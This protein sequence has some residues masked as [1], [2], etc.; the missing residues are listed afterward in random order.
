[1]KLASTLAALLL[2]A[3]LAPLSPVRAASGFI[4]IDDKQYAWALDSINFMKDRNVINGYPPD[5][6]FNPARGVSRAELTA[7]I[8]RLF[9]KYRPNLGAA[10]KL[11]GFNDVPADHWAYNDI[12]DLYDGTFVNN[13]L[14]YDPDTGKLLFQPDRQVSRY[15][16]AEWMGV[17]FDGA[18]VNHVENGNA[19]CSVITSMK[20]VEFKVFARQEDQS[21]AVQADGRYGTTGRAVDGSLYGKSAIY[22]IYMIKDTT[23]CSITDDVS[24]IKA[25][26]LAGL[27]TSGILTA[28]AQG[29]FK[30]Q[31]AISRAEAVTILQRIFNYLS[32]KGVIGQYS[33]FPPAPVFTAAQP[34]PKQPN[35]ARPVP[36]YPGQNPSQTPSPVQAF[37]GKGGIVQDLYK[38]GEINTA[39][40]TAGYTSVTLS[41]VSNDKVDLNLLFDGKQGFLHSEELPKTI[42]LNGI[43][44]MT[45]IT[46]LRDAKSNRP[47]GYYLSSLIVKLN[48]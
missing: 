28:D 10:N 43:Q 2:L 39:I 3:F 17:F 46:Q 29:K 48:K 22:P 27:H 37:D 32:A 35:S 38:D 25:R 40:N 16:F 11:T 8:H 36:D 47:S 21:G 7:M 13:G 6:K 42:P 30:P 5:G 26:A 45:L 31:S 4:D 34:Q 12:S 41:I 1:M 44:S 33:S 9:D 15:Q 19:V 24:A 14:F 23:G 20:D 18:L